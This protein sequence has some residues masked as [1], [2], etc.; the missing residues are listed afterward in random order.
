MVCI[1]GGWD[2]SRMDCILYSES[3]AKAREVSVPAKEHQQKA[4]PV[5]KKRSTGAGTPAQYLRDFILRP[6]QSVIL[7]YDLY[8]S[9]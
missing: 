5:R 7:Q 9:I 1:R 8:Y 6:V 4:L 3:R 2:R